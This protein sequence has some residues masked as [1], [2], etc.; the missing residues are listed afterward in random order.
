ML[1]I[2]DISSNY[3]SGTLPLDCFKNL[4]AMMHSDSNIS[5]LQFEYIKLD[6]SY[7]NTVTVKSKGRDMT[8]VRILTIFTS[9][10]FSNNSFQGNIPDIIG[11][12][13]SLHV[14]DFSDNELTGNI[15]SSIGN[16]M[17]LESLDLSGNFLSGEIPMTLSNLTFLSFLNLSN[18]N[19]IGRVPQGNQLSTF[20]NTSFEGNKGLCGDPL[21]K[22]CD[23]S[24]ANRNH[25]ALAPASKVNWYFV[26]IEFGF[27]V[28]LA[29]VIGIIMFWKK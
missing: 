14:L 9:L 21:S 28:G 20:T 11:D 15:P 25:I 19:L 26:F 4:K 6:T 23:N 7:Q 27:V 16:L 10:D 13:V 17:Q 29:M 12:F 24:S 1:Q 2:F 3:F 18:N 8:L 5:T 22:Q